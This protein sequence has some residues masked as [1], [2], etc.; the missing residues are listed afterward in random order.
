MRDRLIEQI[1]DRIIYHSNT[2]RYHYEVGKGVMSYLAND[3]IGDF[4]HLG[5]LLP[6]VKI[7]E[8]VYT[9]GHGN[10]KKPKEWEV[11]GIWFSKDTTCNHIHICWYKDKDNFASRQISF[12]EIGKT[13][14]LTREEAEQALKE[15]GEG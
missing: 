13:V 2:K 15:S 6:P 9:K 5:G 12:D 14:F 3:L 1:K 7:G 8:T 10:S 4:A 11:I